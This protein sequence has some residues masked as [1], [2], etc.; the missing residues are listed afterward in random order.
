MGLVVV[1][2]MGQVLAEVARVLRPGGVLAGIAP[3]AAAAGAPRRPHPD[4]HQRPAADQAAVPR[5][6]GADRVRRALA[7]VGMRAMEDAR[8]RYRFGIRS[9]ADAELMMSAL[10]L[11]STRPV[12]VE[13]AVDYLADGWT[14][15]G[16]WRWR[17]RC[18][19]SWPSSEGN[20]GAGRSRLNGDRVSDTRGMTDGDQ[21]HQR[22]G[23]R[24]HDHRQRH[25]AR[26]LLGDWCGPCKR[27]APIYEKASEEHSDITFAKLD[28]DANQELSGSWA[29]RAS[30]P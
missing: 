25:R 29:S 3:G 2:P 22:R 24:E 30:R 28:T 17:S 19:G 12:R 15:R 21:E 14:G 6:G 11:P 20:S 27:F 10:Y 5:A 18:G 9:R 7:G 26:R 16:W 8:E 1:Q 4:Q 13:R 23:L